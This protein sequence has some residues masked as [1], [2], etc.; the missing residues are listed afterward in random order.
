ML[1]LHSVRFVRSHLKHNNNNDN[2]NHQNNHQNDHR[3]YHIEI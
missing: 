2:N 3:Q 1:G